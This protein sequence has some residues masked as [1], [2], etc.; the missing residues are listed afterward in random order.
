MILFSKCKKISGR[1]ECRIV[2]CIAILILLTGCAAPNIKLFSD[3]SDPLME[4]VLDGEALEKVVVIS[5]DGVI[6]DEPQEGFLS[7]QMPSMLQEVVSQLDMAAKDPA[8]KALVLKINSPGG[9]ITA[10]D[11][12]YRE[13]MEFKKQ[14]RAKLVVSM[15]DL[16]AS[17]GYYVALPADYIMAHPTTVTGSVGV[18]FMSPKAYNLME[19]IGVAVRVRKSGRNKDMGSP[20]REP[21]AEEDKLLDGIISDMAGRFITL[22]KERRG[23]DN[24]S[25]EAIKT[26]RIFTAN[27]ALEVGLIDEIGYLDD[28]ITKAKCMA[29]L[30]ANARVVAYRRTYF[31]NDNVYNTATTQ[32]MGGSK[33][34]VNVDLLD[35]MPAFKTGFYY[36]WWPS[37]GQ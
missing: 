28:A 14:S 11:I 30:P 15:M 35:A 33:S 12:L 5:V 18:I 16:A 13:L 9:T 24:L 6:T 36:L 37:A 21:T 1:I 4:Q 32:L 7:R 25:L 17:G 23:G 3:A 19:K 27:E 29:G 34:L 2:L 26:A 22:V 8:V 10:S 20:F 31:P